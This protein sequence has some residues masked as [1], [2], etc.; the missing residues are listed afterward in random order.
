VCPSESCAQSKVGELD[1]P[2]SIDENIIWLDVA[3]NK[4]HGMNA[5]NCTRQFGNV[6]SRQRLSRQVYFVKEKIPNHQLA[7]V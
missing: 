6:K 3:M 4:A 1:V 5:F 2:G 7:K